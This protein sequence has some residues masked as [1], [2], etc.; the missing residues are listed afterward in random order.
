VSQQAI[1]V[2]RVILN[3]KDIARSVQVA[4]TMKI[5]KAKENQIRHTLIMKMLGIGLPKMLG[6][7]TSVKITIRGM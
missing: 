7:I 2:N 5:A 1:Q 4:M 6:S 3:K